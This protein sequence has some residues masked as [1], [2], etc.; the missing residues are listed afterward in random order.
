VSTSTGVINLA[1]TT[2]G[3]Y[4]I[5][6]TVAANAGCPSVTDTVFVDINPYIFEGSVSASSSVSTVCEGLG[7]NLFSSATGYL[8]V[9]E[10]ERFNGSINNWVTANN[11]TGGTTSA[12]AWTLRPAGHSING[13]NITSNDATQCYISDARTQG[14]GT[15]STWLRSPALSSVGFTTLSLDFFHFYDDRNATDNCRVQASINGS[16][17][18]DLAT[19]TSDQ[20]S[21]NNFANAVINLNS[22]IGLPTF[23]IRFL[24]TANGGDRYW[25]IDNV[26]ITGNSTN[27]TYN[28]T[29]SPSGYTAALQ[30]PTNV[31]PAAS[32]FYIATATNAY[33][34]SVPA[35]PVG[36]TVNPKPADN[37]GADAILCGG[38]SVSIGA[39]A[40]ANRTYS[41][42]PSTGLSSA[43]AANPQATPSTTTT[44]T[45][46]E[47]NSTTGCSAS[48][49]VLVTV[50][51]VASVNNMNISACSGSSFSSIPQNGTNGTIPL[52][53]TYTWTAPTGTGFSGG[54]AQSTPQSNILQTLTLTGLGAA[55]AIY[56]VTPITNGCNGP[57]FTLTVNITP[58]T[59][60]VTQPVSPGAMCLN[61]ST[62]TISVVASGNNLTYQWNKGVTNLNNNS[63]YSGTTTP[64]LTITNPA[65]TDAGLYFVRVTG[66]CGNP[67]SSGF[68]SIVVNTPVTPTISIASSAGSTACEGN[69]VTFTATITNG[70]TTPTYLWRVNGSPIAGATSSTL[71]KN[72]LQ[73]GDVVTCTLTSSTSCVTSSTVVSNAITM[74]IV[75]FETPQVE[76]S[77]PAT[78]GLCAGTPVTYTAT[79]TFGGTAPVY[80][81]RRNNTVVGTNSPTLTINN[82]TNSDVI[83]CVLTSN[84]SCVA[85]NNVLSN[86]ISLNIQNAAAPAV[87]ITSENSGN[88][89]PGSTIMFTANAANAG[90][91]PEYQ[92]HVNDE[93]VGENSPTF[94]SSSLNAGDEVTCTVTS[95]L[96]CASPEYANSSAVTIV[97]TGAIQYFPDTDEDGYGATSGSMLSCTPV[98]GYVT[99][100]FDCD[101]DNIDINPGTDE[102]YNLLDDN[103]DGSI[104]ETGGGAIFYRDIDGDNYG[105]ESDTLRS[106]AL[107]FGYCLHDGDCNDNN[108]LVNPSRAEICNGIDDDCDGTIDEGCGPLN[109]ETTNSLTLNMPNYPDCS[110]QNGTLSGATIS[111]SGS[112]ATTTGADVWYRFVAPHPGVRIQA[113]SNVNDI[114]IELR[115]SSGVVLKTENSQG[116]GNEVLN[117]GGL[118]AGEAYFVGVRNLNGATAGG[119]FSICGS[120][121]RASYFT[122]SNGTYSLCD[123]INSFYTVANQYTVRFTNT[124]NSSVT[125]FNTAANSTLIPL[126]NC[127]G[128]SWGGSYSVRVDAVYSLTRGNGNLEVITVQGSV[129][130]NISIA[131][132]AVTSVRTS[133]TCPNVKL[134]SSTLTL[135]GWVCGAVD[136]QWEFT[137]TLPSTAAPV[138]V[139]RGTSS[140]T[141]PLN[142]VQG[143]TPN[144]SYTVRVRGVL[145][146]NI[147]GT[148]SAAQCVT[149]GGTT[150]LEILPTDESVNQQHSLRTKRD[151]EDEG[152]T[153]Y[154]FPNPSDGTTVFLNIENMTAPN[155]TVRLTDHTG[156]VV[157]NQLVQA[158][159]NMRLALNLEGQVS[160]GSYQL[161]IQMNNSFKVKRLIV[162]ENN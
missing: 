114:A 14:S 58:A 62:A 129:L 140:T 76:I 13:V 33:G 38:T 139:S 125:V 59:T 91:S 19:Y 79:P 78:S 47:T 80:Q 131:T 54:T 25:C 81:W 122:A 26:S 99:N 152:M 101:D 124:A 77:T 23:Y 147:F 133:D 66:Q 48:N 98:V 112:G 151:T 144:S 96:S 102:W 160:S 159:G 18:T 16:S 51:Q 153:F 60:I 156:R 143:L 157:Y 61:N 12:S 55:Q 36:V 32:T 8:T 35:I 11:S 120:A 17:W 45:L 34:C 83:R 82:L 92:W 121:L 132:S 15:V 141:L 70:G 119:S 39:P 44:Y 106:F 142:L 74:S 118:T 110:L 49:S 29:S 31:I 56:T 135:A 24:Y 86:S 117:F 134:L 94:A 126:S 50:R 130:R 113:F 28:W 136:Y 155:F 148:W 46:T 85:Q 89:C 162:V 4:A 88:A 20:G 3:N 21:N 5:V 2:P 68:A 103:C 43:T 53:T 138:V 64:T 42:S 116:I 137:R 158:T 7:M 73:N 65:A 108:A 40:S 97:Y 105:N 71:I 93:D 146:N 41:W 127:V 145:P 154:L 67:V 104:D 84:R 10:R 52:G 6:N 30:N 75:N 90:T 161:E 22:Y 100:N 72:D 150:A 87:S 27:Y 37:A 63:L 69:N 111:A 57:S 123:N 109:D 149:I 115:N 107:P 1:A 128:L 95:S 9:L